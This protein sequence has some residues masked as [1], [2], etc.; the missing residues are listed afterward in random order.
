MIWT[1]SEKSEP[2]E[3][4]LHKLASFTPACEEIVARLKSR[5]VTEYCQIWLSTTLVERVANTNDLL[6]TVRNT[7]PT[8]AFFEWPSM[9]KRYVHA[10]PVVRLYHKVK[11]YTHLAQDAIV[12]LVG[13]YLVV[14][15]PVDGTEGNALL[16]QRGSTEID[17][18]S[19]EIRAHLNLLLGAGSILG[20]HAVFRRD[21]KSTW[22]SL[23][24]DQTRDSE[25][26]AHENSIYNFL[27][28]GLPERNLLYQRFP[29]EV[30]DLVAQAETSTVPEVRF[31][32]LWLA[33]ER[34]LGNGADRRKFCI[35]QLKSETINKFCFDVFRVRSDWF[36]GANR[37]GTLARYE[38]FL[39]IMILLRYIGSGKVL[40][41][42]VKRLEELIEGNRILGQEKDFLSM[43]WTFSFQEPMPNFKSD[44]AFSADPRDESPLS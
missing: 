25:V 28:D 12:P 22:I 37:E 31:S 33:L 16:K 40:S 17:R 3:I 42:I 19:S 14:Y 18:I 13:N 10:P 30:L 41:H 24:S 43:R 32:I 39:K 1:V 21:V 4:S 15:I 20:V 35:E 27:L 9:E 6:A 26:L 34:A 8:D 2:Q 44:R 38:P 7:L 29:V 36:H 23:E 11:S 5:D